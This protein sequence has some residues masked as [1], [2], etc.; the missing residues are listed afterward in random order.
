MPFWSD[1]QF[2]LNENPTGLWLRSFV[3]ALVLTI[4]LKSILKLV[5]I[6]LRKFVTG[7]KLKWDD[8]AVDLLDGLKTFVLLSWLFYL[9]VRPLEIAKGAERPLTILI[10]AVS[11]YQVG[12]WGLYVLRRWHEDV[13]AEKV[14]N[15]PSGTSAMGLLFLSVQ[16]LFLGIVVLIGL[17]NVGIDIGALLA[18]L[19]VGGIAVALA[20]Q[21]ILGDLLASLSI[22]LDK[23]FVVGDF[24]VVGN[25]V[26]NVEEIGI[27]TTR[28]RS[29]SGEMLVFSNKDLLESRIRNFKR[30]FERRVVQN[31]GVTYN[32]SPDLM[33]AI[34]GW[35]KTYVE[36]D[37]KLRFD[38]CHF[39]KFGD[40]SLDFELV[41]H[42]MA[43]EYNIYMDSQQ[44]LLMKLLRRFAQEGVD[45]AFPT[46]S[47]WVEGVKG[48]E[49][50]SLDFAHK[51]PE[52]SIDRR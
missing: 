22:V 17:S 19:G 52:S 50:K 33:D 27:K 16:A 47:L 8:V 15:D 12:I 7:T 24:I 35:V 28:V 20:A 30:M 41:F 10:V 44:K 6:R 36:E 31:F 2:Y 3:V 29:L 21:N 42:V 32:T 38:R 14:K 49:L 23:P 13:L 34:P 40:S 9:N 45:F 5:S 1:I 46:R 26:G 25:E 48:D 39:M 43:P 18:G 4:L 51:A 11:V 37:P